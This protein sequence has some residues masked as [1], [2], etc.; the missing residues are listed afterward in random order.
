MGR[1]M[2]FLTRFTGFVGLGFREYSGYILGS[3][4]ASACSLIESQ[5]VDPKQL[6]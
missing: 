6:L 4:K 5:V 3:R 2:P 1:P